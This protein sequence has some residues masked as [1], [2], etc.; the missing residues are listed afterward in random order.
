MRTFATVLVAPLAL[1]LAACG[2]SQQS[3]GNTR[4]GKGEPPAA[5]EPAPGRLYQVSATVLEDKSHGPMLCLAGILLSLPP[6]C[7][8]VPITN[9][10]WRGVKAERMNGT[11]SGAYHLVGRY[12]GKTF[13]V[14]ELGPYDP[15]FEPDDGTY[16]EPTSPCRN[17]AGGPQED[18]PAADAYARSRPDYVTSWVTHLDGREAGP[19]ILNVMFS[20]S[21]ERHGEARWKAWTVS[22]CEIERNDQTARELARIRR[23]VEASLGELG[24]QMLWSSGPDIEPIIQIGVV[25]DPEGKAQ[26]TLDARYGPGVV[27]LEP[28]LKPLQSVG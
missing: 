25:A 16:P 2:S 24:L 18:A 13:T 20:G 11:V 4:T 19:V 5:T 23:E 26:T 3:A 27:R 14:V 12:D 10:D 9:W 21:R 22:I 7:G 6:Q 28:A 15:D 8:N 1:V 17:A